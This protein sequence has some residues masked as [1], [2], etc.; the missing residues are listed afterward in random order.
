VGD[1]KIKQNGEKKKL[2]TG[3]IIPDNAVIVTGKKS[4][5]HLYDPSSGIRLTIGPETAVSVDSF[6]KTAQ[7]SDALFFQKFRKGIVYTG[8]S[9][10]AAVRAETIESLND[11]FVL[12]EDDLKDG[13][14]RS[15]E[16]KLFEK[17]EYT[18]IIQIT[19]NAADYEGMFLFAAS[20]YS[21]EGDKSGEKAAPLLE[22][23]IAGTGNSKLKTESMRLLS[24]IYFSQAFYDRSCELMMEAVKNTQE[25][26]ITEADYY[27]LVQ[28]LF[29]L[30]RNE[31]G[32]KYLSRMMKYYPESE[33][34]SKIIKY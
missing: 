34:T 30:N 22:K 6:K 10:T 24:A 20:L 17:S 21:H 16:W 14:D 5:A 19:E 31:E 2:T 12:S 28:S 26:N 25:G 11:E 23:V 8:K 27:I 9:T 3:M 32:E 13:T 4:Q 33:L 18:R 1:I 15:A 29:F 7:I